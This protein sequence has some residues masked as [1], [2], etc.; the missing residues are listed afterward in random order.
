MTGARD[1]P[2]RARLRALLAVTTGLALA[3]AAPPASANLYFNPGGIDLESAALDGTNYHFVNRP[4]GGLVRLTPDGGLASD[5]RYLYLGYHGNDEVGPQGI[6]RVGVDGVGYKRRFVRATLPKCDDDLGGAPDEEAVAVAGPYVYWAD[7]FAGT[8]G[9]ASA[10]DG[11]GVDPQFI[12]T[13]AGAC[14]P[15]PGIGAR[16]LA[17]TGNSVYWSNPEQGT[18]GRAN[19]D[20][21]GVDQSFIAG[22]QDPWSVAVSGSD[23]YWTSASTGTIGRAQLDGTGALVPGSTANSFIT[24]LTPSDA[25]AGP[26]AIAVQGS[27]L[28]FDNG[29]GWIGKASADGATVVHHLLE[30][31]DDDAGRPAPPAIAA[32]AD[33]PSPTTTTVTCGTSS[34]HILEPPRSADLEVGNATGCT[35][36]V[37]HV[38][39]APGPVSGNV[40][41]T[42]APVKGGIV[43]A[44][45][46]L[47]SHGVCAL[48]A[49]KTAGLSTCTFEYAADPSVRGFVRHASRVILTAAYAGETTHAASTGKG[50]VNVVAVH[51]CLR[52]G[53]SFL[54]TCDA[55]GEIQVVTRVSV[56]GQT[57][58]STYPLFGATGGL[59]VTLPKRCVRGGGRFTV[60]LALTGVARSLRFRRITLSLGS[61]RVTLTHPPFSARL[62]LRPR[63]ASLTATMVFANPPTVDFSRTVKLA[64]PAC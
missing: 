54:Q 46:D 38:G 45:G 48:K 47:V 59:A 18:I 25:G 17:V 19:L 1:R 56:K 43:G 34:V 53:E 41:L 52:V 55:R 51:P 12:S 20:G 16:G 37:R 40:D 26:A 62:R 21:S 9:R 4:P 32:D 7:P 30:V 8:I 33:Q 63:N 5:G 10:A 6:D 31:Y 2:G 23:L 29:D 50:E 13:A 27:T 49:T 15:I 35:V 3:A 58:T 57:R 11:S 36:T 39:P 22:A 64:P 60:A 44:S 14:S 42:A 61:Q 24:G 28:Y